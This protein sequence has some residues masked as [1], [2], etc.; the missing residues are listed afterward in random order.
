MR[1]SSSRTT[2]TS[3]PAQSTSPSSPILR[4]GAIPLSFVLSP[5]S[6]FHRSDT[7]HCVSMERVCPSPTPPSSDKLTWRH[8]PS[9]PLRTTTPLLTA[10]Q[11]KTSRGITPNPRIRPTTSRTTLRF[12]RYARFLNHPVIVDQSQLPTLVSWP[13]R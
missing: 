7:Q 5:I 8:P 1:P 13:G 12:T 3:L 10:N 11:S 4:Q 9:E 2:I 6:P